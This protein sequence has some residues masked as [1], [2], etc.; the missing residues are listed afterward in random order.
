MNRYILLLFPAVREL[1]KKYLRDIRPQ[2][3]P[4]SDALFLN[5]TGERIKTNQINVSLKEFA[6]KSGIKTFNG[7]YLTTHIFRH[8]F[9]SLNIAPLGL[10]LNLD[11][12][13][14]R[15]RH[16][17][18]ALAEKVYILDNP[19]VE[20][21]KHKERLSLLNDN[22]HERFWRIP[23]A[24]FVGWLKDELQLSVT[25]I[26]KVEEAHDL[27]NPEKS[28]KERPQLINKKLISEDD[29]LGLLSDFDLTLNSLRSYCL[30]NKYCT[31]FKGTYKYD[32]E[33]IWKLRNDYESR[34]SA[35]DKM[36]ISLA[37]F[38]RLKNKLELISIGK[39]SLVKKT[40]VLGYI[41][42]S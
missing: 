32:E 39:T 7:K 28:V 37:H 12:I 3:Q 4:K 9:A 14:S 16:K 40:A 24:V 41:S 18:R 19:D 35:L 38:Y 26:S 31:E 34:E 27:H 8:T 2:F 5:R 29:A 6:N 42:K 20:K 22:N 36:G 21:L 17:D 25:L 15:L 13:I 30:K 23:K 11:Q 1:L 33:F 10:R